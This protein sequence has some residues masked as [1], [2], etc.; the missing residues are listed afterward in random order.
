MVSKD[1]KY[2]GLERI[3]SIGKEFLINNA[4]DAYKIQAST[5]EG[6]IKLMKKLKPIFGNQ[7]NEV[8]NELLALSKDSTATPSEN[9]KMLL[10]SR[11]LDFQPVSLSEMPEY[12]LK[13]G[14]WR[15]LY[16]LKTFGIKQLDI[17]R[18]EVWKDLK[19]GNAQQKLDAITRMVQLMGVLALANAGADE[20]KDF[21][22]GKE[23]KFSDIVFENFLTMGG[24]NR[25]VRMQA[26]REGLG[27]AVGQIILPPFK[28]VNSLSKD[29]LSG[30]IIDPGKARTLE[31][32]P[33][34][35]K[36]AYWNV[37]RGSEYRPSIN[38]QEFNKI[39]KKFR[40]FKKEFKETN[41]KRL[42][43]QAN[44]DDF[45][46]MKIYENFSRGL[47][48]ITTLINK[49]KKLDQTTNIRRRIG[50]LTE[51]Q[52]QLRQRY[53]NLIER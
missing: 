35:G 38:E 31:S 49:L 11:L 30:E 48:G 13:G 12:Y 26:R 50:Q 2:V 21:M 34:I 22:M 24:A 40:L 20:L 3:D 37:G 51:R 15:I 25:Y 39:G 1:F 8:I 5:K 41:D 6:R 23:T 32:L 4:F 7:S 47:K 17:F 27:T 45:K 9:M 46:Q 10:Y 33:L 28:F 52:N 19:T 14:N 29:I 16:M 42:F 44:A 18:N 53:F 43:L 36:L